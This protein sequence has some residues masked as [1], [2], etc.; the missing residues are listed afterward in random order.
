MQIL[1]SRLKHADRVA[2][3]TQC[4]HKLKVHRLWYLTGS[5][6]LGECC[7][8]ILDRVGDI[9]GQINADL[10]L[11]RAGV[12]RP[13]LVVVCYQEYD[14]DDSRLENLAECDAG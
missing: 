11:F 13:D 9:A 12:V 8:D 14:Q 3:V 5:G 6:T 10:G 7:M 2:V 4:S 1:Y